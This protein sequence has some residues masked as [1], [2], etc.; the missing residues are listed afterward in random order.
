[1]RTTGASVKSLADNFPRAY[2]H[3]TDARVR[4]REPAPE[5][6]QFQRATEETPISARRSF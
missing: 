1:V 5:R 6:G 2:E 4:K 3:R